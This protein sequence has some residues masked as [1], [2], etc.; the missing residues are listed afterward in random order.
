[1]TERE[2]FGDLRRELRGSLVT[3]D[4]PKER[5]DPLRLVQEAVR[6]RDEAAKLARR[7]GDDNERFDS[8]WCVCDVDEHHRLEDAVE[9]AEK[10]RINMAVSNPCF[11]LWPALHFDGCSRHMTANSLKQ[12]LRGNMKGYDKSLDCRKLDGLRPIAI[13]NAMELER[14]HGR[15]GNALNSNPSTGVWRLVEKLEK[16]AGS[17]GLR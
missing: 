14:L 1:M 15:N 12:L 7:L 6:R 13:N 4:I 16:C 8:V 2:Y 5:G 9:L 17:P 3:I 10:K 11:E